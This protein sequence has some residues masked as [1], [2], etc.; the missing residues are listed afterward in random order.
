MNLDKTTA[1][2]TGANRGIGK[3]LVLE[4]VRRGAK[5]YAGAR[6]VSSLDIGGVVPIE[7][8]I[9]KA[10]SIKAATGIASDVNCLVNNAGIFTG[11]SLLSGNLDDIRL[12]METHY[13]GTLS[14]V[15]AFAPIISGNG[16]GSILNM[17]SALSWLSFDA[18]GAYSAAKS[19]EWALTNALRLELA[20]M[21]IKVSGLHVGYVNTDMTADVEAEKSDPADIAK[22]A[23]DGIESGMYEI[24]ADQTSRMVQGG[25]AGGV[26]ALYPQF[27]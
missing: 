15:R 6:D 23:I 4:L 20:P 1:L 8:D 21:N 14:M 10:D 9:T 27:A 16:G 13:F 2:I 26:S 18:T 25:L 24:L 7:V 11:A 5:V 3:Q 22:I 19:A 12:E 17:L